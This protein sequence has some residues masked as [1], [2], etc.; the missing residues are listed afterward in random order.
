MK[1]ITIIGGGL[2]GLW[3]ALKLS[4]QF[5]GKQIQ[6]IEKHS[7]WGGRIYGSREGYDYGAAR[8]S[9]HHRRVFR[10]LNQCHLTG[11]VQK[12]PSPTFY[13]DGQF[14]HDLNDYL[15]EYVIDSL[16]NVY[17]QAVEKKD[18]TLIEQNTKTWL[19]RH[20]SRSV[21]HSL[22]MVVPYQDAF[23]L[24]NAK[25][26]VRFI[27]NELDPATRYYKLKG[28]LVQFIACLVRKLHRRRNVRIIKK[29]TL[30]AMNFCTD[31]VKLACEKGTFKTRRV[32]L[33]LPPHHIKKLRVYGCNDWNEIRRMVDL[34][35]PHHLV[36][37]YGT[38]PGSGVFK[39][40]GR[41]INDTPLRNL[42]KVSTTDP[43]T[44]ALM[45]SYV[46]GDLAKNMASIIH[47]G[48][49][50]KVVE[51]SLQKIYP[52]L[53]LPKGGNY[54]HYD[55]GISGFYIPPHVDRGDFIDFFKQTFED[56]QLLIVGD[57]YSSYPIWM[58]GSLQSAQDGVYLLK[59]SLRQAQ[60]KNKKKKRKADKAHERGLVLKKDEQQ[61][62]HHA[63]G[64]V[65][66][67]VGRRAEQAATS[68]KTFSSKELKNNT[69]LIALG[70][71]GKTV[72]VFNISKWA[73]KHPGGS[74]I[75][76]GTQ[77]GEN[78]FD[79][80]KNIGSHSGNVSRIDKIFKNSGLIQVVGKLEKSSR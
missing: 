33:A 52:R 38:Y 67:Q 2:S 10:A 16:R 21:V 26:G 29:N 22:Y 75:F 41:N 53:K 71:E 12:N 35:V 66:D 32:V 49:L 80:F 73:P 37:V 9:N 61:R 20:F 40:I 54:T 76:N 25:E 51:S 11:R 59:T 64:K 68:F 56:G 78:A 39:G 6:L 34:P 28:G 27:L 14:Y 65:I 24:S 3:M 7:R 62:S 50:P 19:N 46:D 30:K 23:Y 15:P 55:W 47:K 17:T 36:R 77:T 31:H 8:F 5:P 57:T 18:R 69:H 44:S 45:V 74:A 60:S 4:R 79:M 1:D 58:E 63:L 43:H 48:L 70:D 13:L 72:Y 42:E